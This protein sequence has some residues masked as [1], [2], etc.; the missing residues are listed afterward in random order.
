MSQNAQQEI[1]D[2]IFSCTRK[3]VT[4]VNSQTTLGILE[5]NGLTWNRFFSGGLPRPIIVHSLFRENYALSMGIARKFR[6]M[7]TNFVWLRHVGRLYRNVLKFIKAS[8]IESLVWCYPWVFI[9]TDVG[10]LGFGSHPPPTAL[11]RATISVSRARSVC[12]KASSALK[13]VRWASNTSKYVT[14]P[15]R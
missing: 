12:T 9:S 13:T 1:S 2:T 11:Y 4:T 8:S 10:S 7:I 5:K 14:N 3:I 15:C 6:L